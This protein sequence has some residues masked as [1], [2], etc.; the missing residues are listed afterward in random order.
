MEGEKGKTIITLVGRKEVKGDKN[1][2]KNML[3]GELKEIIICDFL[4]KERERTKMTSW[5]EEENTRKV[6][7]RAEMID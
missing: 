3:C 5:R 2:K 7:K 1:I 4:E 6:K